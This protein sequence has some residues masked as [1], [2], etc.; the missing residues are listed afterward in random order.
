MEGSSQ[1]Q[2]QVTGPAGDDEEYGDE[3][4]DEESMNKLQDSRLR[5]HLENEE[6]NI[7]S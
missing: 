2:D 1:V 7:A 4:Q 5:K 3:D 6:I